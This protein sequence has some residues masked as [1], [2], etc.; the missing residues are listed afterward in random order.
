MIAYILKSI[1]CLALLLFF[2]HFILEKEKMHNFNRFY[3]MGAVLFSFLVPLTTI[4]ITPELISETISAV[5]SFEEPI[6]FENTTPKLLKKLLII[7]SYLLVY[8]VLFH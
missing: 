4:E 8:T 5:Q 2:Y 1:S 7:L 3:L 6:N